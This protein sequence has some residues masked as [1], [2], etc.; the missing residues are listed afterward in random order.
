MKKAK[1]ARHI[2]A[3]AGLA[4]SAVLLVGVAYADSVDPAQEQ[5]ASKSS[6][7]SLAQILGHYAGPVPHADRIS[8]D[9]SPVQP[10]AV[11][12]ADE[13]EEAQ[14][15]TVVGDWA[16]VDCATCHVEGRPDEAGAS[17]A[18]SHVALGISCTVCHNDESLAKLHAE[19]DEDDRAPKRLRKTDVKSA[20]CTQAGCHDDSSALATAT[21]GVTILTDK[22]GVTVNPHAI[23]ATESHESVTCG[24]CHGGHGAADPQKVC[25]R[26]HHENVYQCGTCHA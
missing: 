15:Q 4:L 21:E 24:N 7:I 8:V 17:M 18:A 23:P 22:D 20:T 9:V 16:S 19:V 14:D 13:A 11:D 25:T 5:T 1:G 3:I 26:C 6:E 10:E 2:L 12:E